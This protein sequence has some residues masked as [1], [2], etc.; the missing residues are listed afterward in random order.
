MDQAIIDK[1]KEN[2]L[3]EKQHLEAEMSS[4]GHKS[5]GGNEV[6]FPQ[7]G[8]KDDENAAEVALFSDN[9]SLEETVDR[10][11]RDVNDALARITKG[12]YGTCKYCGKPIDVNRLIARPASS[13]C[14]LCK[15]K[16]SKRSV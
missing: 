10:Q 5:N 9:L 3:K 12:T 11:L 15:E 8:N 2:L 1:I 14:V 7:L 16:I 6:D 13:S 4:L